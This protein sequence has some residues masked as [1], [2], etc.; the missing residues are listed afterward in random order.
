MITLYTLADVIYL[1]SNFEECTN[2]FNMRLVVEPAFSLYLQFF[3][4][5][6]KKKKKKIEGE[7]MKR[8]K[9]RK[10]RE[11]WDMREGTRRK[12]EGMPF[13]GA[14][15]IQFVIACGM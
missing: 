12:D 6:S 7:N 10:M 15:E 3:L 13:N 14:G 5:F 1:F 8:K 9:E 2:E 11:R 4:S